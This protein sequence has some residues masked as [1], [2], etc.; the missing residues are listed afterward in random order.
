MRPVLLLG[1]VARVVA[2]ACPENQVPWPSAPSCQDFGGAHK[3]AVAFLRS[4]APP[5][6]ILN[7]ISLFGQPG[8]GD[9]AGIA[10]LG[11]NLSLTAKMDL[12]WAV[13]VPQDVFN[14]YVLPYA[15]V[16]E[17]RTNWRQLLFSALMP[18]VC[19]PNSTTVNASL[20]IDDV[21]ALVNGYAVPEQSVWTLFGRKVVFKSSQTPL[22]FDPM[23]VLAFGFASCTGVSILLVDALR[24]LGVPARVAGTPAWNGLAANGNHNWVEI[25]RGPSVGW[26]FYEALP[27]GGGET[28]DNPCDKPVFTDDVL[29]FPDSLC[30]DDQTFISSWIYFHSTTVF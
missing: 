4:N 11:A 29:Q 15:S 6:D 1:V 26:S 27:A 3:E 30:S 23:S 10:S 22:I 12:P 8:A 14:D 7:E 18:L 24:A 16:N 28:L 5:V 2:A 19:L 20:T 25:W 21:A 9:N 13:A 17:A